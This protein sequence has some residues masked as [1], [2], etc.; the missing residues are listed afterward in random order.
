MR[1][2]EPAQAIAVAVLLAAVGV[3]NLL[4]T[5]G[6]G[7]PKH[8]TL[9]YSYIGIALAV[10]LAVSV[11]WRNRVVSPFAAI[12][13]AFFVTLA[14]G[15]NSLEVPHLAA[16]AGSVGFAVVVSMRQRKELRAQAPPRPAAGR[17]RRGRADPEPDSSAKR[18]PEPNRR[19]T[20]PAKVTPAKGKAVSSTR[21]ATRRRS[22][23]RP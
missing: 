14:R 9:V 16:L 7:A 21:T 8:P 6:P 2:R 23:R 15:P 22:S 11:K 10:G 18:L 3:A 20:P 19:Y 4:V 17:R 1:G 5:T 12:F 13:A